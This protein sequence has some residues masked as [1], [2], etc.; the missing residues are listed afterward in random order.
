MSKRYIDIKVVNMDRKRDEKDRSIFVNTQDGKS[1]VIKD[2]EK[3]TV[4][5]EV[6]NN[7]KDAKE[8]IYALVKSDPDKPARLMTKEHCRIDVT[9]LSGFYY[10]DKN[11]NKIEKVDEKDFEIINAEETKKEVIEKKKP[12]RK[13]AKLVEALA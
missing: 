11:G 3:V 2:G 4:L 7:L 5:E 13:P 12:G 9:E 10:K 1:L 8:I 6:Y